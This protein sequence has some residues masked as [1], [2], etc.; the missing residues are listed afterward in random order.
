MGK[1]LYCDVGFIALFYKTK[2][3][4]GKKRSYI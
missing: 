4:S 1:V 2:L 3:E